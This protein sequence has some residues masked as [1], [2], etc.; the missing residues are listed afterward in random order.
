MREM[1]R[2]PSEIH[3]R[4]WR[5]GDQPWY[6]SDIRVLAQTLSWKP[7]ISL[8]EGLASLDRWLSFRFG[9]R[10]EQDAVLAEA[11]Q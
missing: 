11:A 3:Y 10:H 5:P 8:R 2:H 4:S 1:D 9:M 7:R 6:I